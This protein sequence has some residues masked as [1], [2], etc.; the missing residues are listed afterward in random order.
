MTRRSGRGSS[1]PARGAELVAAVP[2]GL[3]IPRPGPLK[4]VQ[5]T[6]SAAGV[7][8]ACGGVRSARNRILR[9]S[10]AR[11]VASPVHHEK[12]FVPLVA[13]CAP[14]IRWRCWQRQQRLCITRASPGRHL[15]APDGIA[16]R[17]EPAWLSQIWRFDEAW[18]EDPAYRPA[19]EKPCICGAFLFVARSRVRHLCITRLAMELGGVTREE[20][21][22]MQAVASQSAG[23]AGN[24]PRAL[25]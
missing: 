10:P 16:D 21:G 14:L 24:P 12:R 1:R 20:I 2:L 11:A 3:L 7:R 9:R 8:A 13:R 17:R 19:T 25:R 18:D 22:V 6:C 15:A 4:R 5:C 23:T